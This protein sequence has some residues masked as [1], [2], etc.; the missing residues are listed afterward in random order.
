MGQEISARFLDELACKQKITN[1]YLKQLV[2]DTSL[3][4]AANQ[5]Y[6]NNQQFVVSGIS[7]LTFPANTYHSISYVV[8]LGTA[9]ITEAG[10]VFEDAPKGYAGESTATTLLSN[11]FVFQG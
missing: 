6:D 1:Q 2:A 3:I 11:A 9:D 7:S 8:V 10:V 5:L 4:L